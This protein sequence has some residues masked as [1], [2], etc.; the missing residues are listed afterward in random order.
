MPESGKTIAS[1]GRNCTQREDS[2]ARLRNLLRGNRQCGKGGIYAVCSAHPAVIG[3]AVRQSLEDGSA[4]LVE[5]TSNQVNQVGGYTGL[6]PVDFAEFVHSMARRAGLPVERVLLGGDHIGPFPWRNEVS[7]SALSKACTLVHDCV[8]TGYQKIHLDASM[9]CGD[10][11]GSL[12][13][14]TVAKRAAILCNVAEEAHR[15]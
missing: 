14:Q 7:A 6:T 13:E 8:I 11:N 4:L 10:D 3:A 5:S 12:T 1:T 15:E 2:S 9:P